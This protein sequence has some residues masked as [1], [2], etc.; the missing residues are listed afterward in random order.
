[1]SFKS[2]EQISSACLTL[3]PASMKV[4]PRNCVCHYPG[5][6]QSLINGITVGMIDKL[7]CQLRSP[8]QDTYPS[9]Y[10]RGTLSREDA[11]L[12]RSW[13][14]GIAVIFTTLIYLKRDLI[15]FW[16]SGPIYYPIVVMKET[17]Y[18]LPT[19]QIMTSM[20]SLMRAGLIPA[21]V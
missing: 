7:Y 11:I 8:Y 20:A 21:I 3:S 14:S 1:M 16:S 9:D 15:G 5:R 13:H 12:I 18:F 2:W 10:S 17:Y 19:T 4:Q 6:N